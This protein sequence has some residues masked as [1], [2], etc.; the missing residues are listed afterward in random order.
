MCFPKHRCN[1]QSIDKVARS[2]RLFIFCDEKMEERL[3]STSL[4][5]STYFNAAIS[6]GQCLG[7]ESGHKVGEKCFK[8]DGDPNAPL[9]TGS[10]EN[11]VCAIM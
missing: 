5:D 7:G 4:R 1:K 8:K 6:E 10:A 3:D 11:G 2:A 9:L